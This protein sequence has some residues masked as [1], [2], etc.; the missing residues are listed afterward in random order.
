M[1]ELLKE[2][3]EISASLEEQ[4]EDLLSYLKNDFNILMDERNRFYTITNAETKMFQSTPRKLKHFF[5]WDEIIQIYNTPH[6]FFERTFNNNIYIRNKYKN[7]NKL[8]K[9]YVYINLK[10]MKSKGFEVDSNIVVSLPI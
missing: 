5:S 10:K 3:K 2:P 8:T 9:K 4:L 7:L 1:P 6:S